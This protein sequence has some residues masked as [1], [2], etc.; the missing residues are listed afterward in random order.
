MGIAVDP[1]SQ[2]IQEAV[3]R[4]LAAGVPVKRLYSLDEAAA[5]LGVGR[6]T[7]GGLVRKG[8]LP[9]VDLDMNR[10]LIDIEDL[11]RFVKERKR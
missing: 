1:F 7:V 4:G 3:Q 8:D 5:Y 10:A 2:L 6:T 11:D 9:T